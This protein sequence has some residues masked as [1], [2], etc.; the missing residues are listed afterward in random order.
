M[1]LLTSGK[2]Q[3]WQLILSNLTPVCRKES[4]TGETT[5]RAR[6]EVKGGGGTGGWGRRKG[7]RLE[8][9]EP[10]GLALGPS[11]PALPQPWTFAGKQC[12]V[13]RRG[14]LRVHIRQA[15]A[16]PNP[17][18]AKKATVTSAAKTF[19]EFSSHSLLLALS[20]RSHA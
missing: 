8:R 14:A 9:S 12:L 13:L 1:G 20:P 19:P 18:P 4:E 5:R 6:R 17:G 16:N 7:G 2:M 3:L 15:A 10:A 11:H